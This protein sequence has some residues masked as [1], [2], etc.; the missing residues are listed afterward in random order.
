[1]K[2]VLCTPRLSKRDADKKLA[3]KTKAPPTVAVLDAGT[4]KIYAREF[5]RKFP[6]LTKFLKNSQGYTFKVKEFS[7]TYD[8]VKLVSGPLELCG[9]RLRKSGEFDTVKFMVAGSANDVQNKDL[10]IKNQQVNDSNVL[11][12]Y[13]NWGKELRD[14]LRAQWT[15]QA[16]LFLG[17]RIPK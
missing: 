17:I 10:T 6:N 16:A 2:L 1:M 11:S 5:A 15:V 3:D 13:N 12:L 4:R 8:V 9:F 14:F 7:N